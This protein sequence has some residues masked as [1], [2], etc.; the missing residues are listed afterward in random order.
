M[1][2]QNKSERDFAEQKAILNNLLHYAITDL[3]V[4][5]NNYHNVSARKVSSV[6]V[7][8]LQLLQS[9]SIDEKGIS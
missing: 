3:Q 8:V 6:K 4:F 7:S 2:N 9:L 1:S 5:L